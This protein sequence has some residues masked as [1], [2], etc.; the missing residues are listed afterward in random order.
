MKPTQPST[1]TV[2]IVE[3]DR[4]VASSIS[5]VIS[6]LG[7]RSVTARDGREA[8][9]ALDDHPPAVM[10]V[11]MFMP[12]MGGSEFLGMVRRSPKWSRIPRVI[13]TGTNDSMIG[14]REDAPVLF[15]PVD[16]RTLAEVV[17]TYCEQGSS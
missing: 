4:D 17:R 12:E 13:I 3:D 6:A 8:V 16:F 5:D 9:V 1:T 7:Y 2:L 14:V 11:D 15:K 10:L